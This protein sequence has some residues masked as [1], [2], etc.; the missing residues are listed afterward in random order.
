M[1][2]H[3]FDV[4]GI[5]N[6]IVDVLARSDD[7]F[8]ADNDLAKGAMTL[9]DEDRAEQL[10]RAMHAPV[11]QSG[12]SA[13]NTIAALASLGARAAFIGKVRDDALGDSFRRAI[14]DEGV[15]FDTPAANSGLATARCL[16]F[17]T[18]DA[19][20]TMNT[21]LGASTDF[22][23][24][25]LDEDVIRASAITYLEGYLWDKPAAKQAFIRAAEIAHEAGNR[26]ALSLS[27]AFCVDRHRDDFLA[28]V[29]GHVDILFANEDE[30]A[31]LYQ[32]GSFDDALQRVRGHCEIAAL[33]RSEKGS[34]VI[35][36]DEFHVLDAEH[37]AE[38]VDT[39]GAGDAYAA[40]FLFGL[41]RDLGLETA[42]R[43]GGIAAAEV[44]SHIG[45]R[46]AKPLGELIAG[47]I[48]RHL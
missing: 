22:G 30:I 26:V 3:T 12:G 4:V 41:A 9:I 42:G 21:F 20:R 29:D 27:D 46:P 15:V 23:D 10:Y 2:E 38:V 34:V 24:G 16:I 31:S 39:T 8:L 25:D 14:R 33:T 36:G 6:A 48:E 43:I 32:S 40:G 11:E 47:R 35:A 13:A 1:T 17:V 37:V 45:A 44:I 28:L 18:P 7:S 19:Q 5:G